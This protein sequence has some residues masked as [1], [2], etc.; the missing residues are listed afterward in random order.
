ISLGRY[1]SAT[2]LHLLLLRRR[3]PLSRRLFPYTTLFRSVLLLISSTVFEIVLINS[4]SCEVK[5][6]DPLNFFSPSLTAVIL[7]K[8][9][10]FVGSSI[11]RTFAC[12]SIIL[13]SIART[14]SP[15]ERTLAF[16]FASSPL[17]SILPKNPRRKVSVC[18]S[19][20]AYWRSHSTRLKSTPSK[21]SELS[22]GK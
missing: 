8:S 20:G 15:P 1:R 19:G 7:S 3:P 11:K 12:D 9:R 6:I 13:L 5:I 22:F 14:F 10:W 4:R 16:F 2:G 17:N 18:S 21:Y